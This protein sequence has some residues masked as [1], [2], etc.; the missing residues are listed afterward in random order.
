MEDPKDR[1]EKLNKLVEAWQAYGAQFSVFVPQ[2]QPAPTT[3]EP[4]VEEFDDKGR[5]NPHYLKHWKF[6]ARTK[7]FLR[8][9]YA[10]YHILQGP[11][12]TFDCL[13]RKFQRRIFNKSY[14]DEHGNPVFYEVKDS[15]EWYERAI[16][17]DI[18]DWQ[19]GFSCRSN[20]C[21]RDWCLM[22]RRN[23]QKIVPVD[24]YS[25]IST[26][27]GISVAVAKSHVAK[28]FKLKLGELESKGIRPSTRSRRKVPKKELMALL[29]RYKNM[30]VQ[31]VDALMAELK[32]VI[33]RSDVVEWH[34]RLFDDDYMFMKDRVVDNLFKIKGPAVKA[35]IWLLMRQEELAK[36]TKGP[37][38]EVSD[39]ELA[40]GLGISKRTACDYRVKLVKLRLVEAKKTKGSKIGEIAITRTIY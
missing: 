21:Q 6:F 20:L 10:K 30:R 25:L 22:H 40:E 28:W 32:G 2:Q 7:D 26:F 5:T 15:Y 16:R 23:P 31:H 9:R 29:D 12:L 27:E 1:D 38:L 19:V 34:R 35:H 8:E 17:M 13:V 39:S 24:I 14:Q 4:E 3:W 37:G 18:F 11:T 36:N 33:E